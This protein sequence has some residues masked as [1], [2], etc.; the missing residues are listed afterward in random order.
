MKAL[1]SSI[2][3]AFSLAGLAPVQVHAQDWKLELYTDAQMSSCSFSYS[4]PQFFQVHIFHTGKMPAAESLVIGFALYLPP[5]LTNT[6]Y[7][8]DYFDTD[9]LILQNTQDDLGVAI[10]YR[11]CAPLPIYLGYVQFYVFGQ[12]ESCCELRPSIPRIPAPGMI[13]VTCDGRT[14]V[15]LEV[16]RVIVNPTPACPC[17]SP[18]ALQS[19]TWGG[20]K[21]LYR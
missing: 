13:G 3:L 4:G 17:E 18:V 9:F 5:C 11:G 21:A 20:V 15:P 14:D 1:A 12:V 2:G 10:S 16:G 19:T 8:G 6:V 7:A